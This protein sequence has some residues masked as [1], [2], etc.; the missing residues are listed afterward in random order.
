MSNDHSRAPEP[1]GNPRPFLIS[2]EGILNLAA[3]RWLTIL[4]FAAITFVPG[5]LYVYLTDREYQVS[6]LVRP[7]FAIEQS[8]NSNLLSGFSGLNFGGSLPAHENFNRYHSYLTSIDVAETL[9][10]EPRYVHHFFGEAWH[11]EDGQW[12]YEKTLRSR[13][14]AAL[15]GIFL[16]PCNF[17]MTASR[18]SEELQSKLALATDVE[19]DMLTL[20]TL[21]RDP[22]IAAELLLAIHNLSDA[23]VREKELASARAFLDSLESSAGGV[24]ITEV[25][26]ALYD[27]MARQHEKIAVVKSDVPYAAELVTGPWI[28]PEPVRPAIF[29]TLALSILVGGFLGLLRAVWVEA[30]GRSV[31]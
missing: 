28:S 16:F 3:R 26:T 8:V 11:L 7:V 31:E 19:S 13:A 12:R 15:C 4:T 29:A 2:V 5:L 27:I 21:A 1:I 20:S 9:L 23:L 18:F 25:R 22:Q 30:G 17:E 6:V 24:S 14:K 10:A